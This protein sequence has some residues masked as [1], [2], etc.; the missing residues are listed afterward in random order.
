MTPYHTYLIGTFLQT[1][2]NSVMSLVPRFGDLV[3]S[4]LTH[5]CAENLESVQTIPRLFRRTNRE[6]CLLFCHKDLF[7]VVKV[8]SKPSGYVSTV[9]KPVSLIDVTMGHGHEWGKQVVENVTEK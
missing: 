1:C 3:I 5:Q 2:D 4:S 6:V 7:F 8:P 9:L